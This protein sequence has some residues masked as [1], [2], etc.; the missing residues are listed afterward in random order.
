MRVKMQYSVDLEEVPEES[1]ALA[2]RA[3]EEKLQAG[4]NID[5][6]II[7]MGC[8]DYAGVV[9]SIDK[10]RRNLAEADFRLGDM[11]AI[12]TGYL[13]AKHAPQ[14]EQP[15]FEQLQERLETLKESLSDVDG[16]QDEQ[17]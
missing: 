2:R 16:E 7:L 3:E 10:A 13:Q 15:D 1:L 6:I 8:C 5:D 12:L 14:E 9:D 4:N 11:S 17:V